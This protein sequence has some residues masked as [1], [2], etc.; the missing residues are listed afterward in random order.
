VRPTPHVPTPRRIR[1]A[2]LVLV[3]FS[4][5]GCGDD[6]VGAENPFADLAGTWRATTFRYTRVEK[7]DEAPVDLIALG[8]ELTLEISS[9]GQLVMTTR[10][11]GSATS[12]TVVGSGRIVEDGRLQLDTGGAQPVTLDYVQAGNF[13]RLTG[14]FLFEPPS[15]FGGDPEDVDLDAVLTRVVS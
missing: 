2:A 8:G 6:G 10:E 13:L 15:L 5:A 7:P 3:L 12:E 1:A 14:R 11:V 9:D 4:P